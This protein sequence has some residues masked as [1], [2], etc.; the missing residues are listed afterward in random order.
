M[1]YAELTQLFH[2][3]PHEALRADYVNAI[4]EDNILG[5]KT[6][7]TRRLTTQRLSELYG[8]DPAI[9]LFRIVRAL[10]NQETEP[11]GRPLLALLCSLA[12]DPL[13]R[14]SRDAAC[15][16]PIGREFP[17]T[18]I[19][20]ALARLGQGR[21]NAATIAKIVRNVASSWTQSG[22]F[23]GRVRKVR[24]VVRPTPASVTF[25][26]MLGYMEGLRGRSLFSSPW[27]KVF[28]ASSFELEQ[29]AIEARRLG[30]LD[31][32][33]SPDTAEISF[34]SQFGLDSRSLGNVPY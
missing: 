27:T 11:S 6:L 8:L 12:R 26:C 9:P 22:H 1:M 19:S 21:L 14:A 7:S 30:L 20:A 2:S 5:K 25:A 10:W 17:R 24:T 34:P 33:L 18:D 16:T 32:K 29:A 3:V 4:S 31:L 23:T 13:L 28:D 15:L